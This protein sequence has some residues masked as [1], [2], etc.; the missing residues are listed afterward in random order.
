MSQNQNFFHHA[1]QI[2]EKIIQKQK[3]QEKQE[4]KKKPAKMVTKQTVFSELTV[5]HDHDSSYLI[6]LESDKIKD[7]VLEANLLQNQAKTTITRI[8]KTLYITP[9][10]YFTNL[11]TCLTSP[12]NLDP[13]DTSFLGLL[14]LMIS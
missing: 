4:T 6:S 7:L 3:R 11:K 10:T 5:T 2:Q 14:A 12:A 13:S 9:S 8:E 1:E